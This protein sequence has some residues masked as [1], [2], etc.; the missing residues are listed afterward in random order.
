MVVR[1]PVRWTLALLVLAS[2][3]FGCATHRP[4]DL[5]IRNA[6]LVVG[7]GTTVDDGVVAVRDGRFVAAGADAGVWKAP[8][9]IDAAGKT[10][11]PGLI[12]SHIH[13]LALVS[14]NEET[15]ARFRSEKLAAVLEG[16]LEMGV[17][18]VRSTGD[19]LEAIL[20]VREEL[21][22]GALAGP[23]L[24]VAGPVLTSVDG[25]P[26]VTVCGW[27]QWPWCREH[28]VR[29]L[30]DEEAARRVV[31]ELADAG[32]DYIKAVHDSRLGQA[33]EPAILEAIAAQSEVRGLEFFVHGGSG[34]LSVEAVAAGADGLVHLPFGEIDTDALLETVG[35]APISGTLG[36]LTPFPDLSGSLR[37]PYGPWTEE[38]EPARALMQETARALWESGSMLAFGTDTP[39][40]RP[41]FS[42]KHEIR[43]LTEAGFSPSDVLLMA[44]RNAAVAVGVD[45]ELGTLEVGKRADLVLVDGQPLQELKALRNVVLVV[46]DGVVVVDRRA[47]N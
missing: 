25:H 35:E 14:E 11:L 2:A 38:M 23:R 43:A 21:S 34:R 44:T 45:D 8:E 40:F 4:A 28:L 22:S 30:E 12:D 41:A 16:F 3:L 33:L 27:G 31:D 5:V 13:L 6:T 7:D 32:V 26:A 20:E 9:E 36:L 10:V 39:M 47:A 42:W 19:P 17:T 46:K 24:V 29:E 1:H 18:T 37:T 15:V